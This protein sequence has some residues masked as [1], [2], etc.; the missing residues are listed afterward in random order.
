MNTHLPE[1]EHATEHA[2]RLDADTTKWPAYRA[3]DEIDAASGDLAACPPMERPDVPRPAS[4]RN[5]FA[6]LRAARAAGADDGCAGEKRDDAS[7]EAALRL[8]PPEV[9]HGP[10]L[11]DLAA[12]S[13]RGRATPLVSLGVAVVA[14]A[15]FV[16][17]QSHAGVSGAAMFGNWLPGSAGIA[18]AASPLPVSD[19]PAK[20][21]LLLVQ[22]ATGER[23]FM[24]V[25]T[26]ADGAV[27]PEEALTAG[28]TWSAEQFAAADKDSN[29][30]L[31][32]DEFLSATEG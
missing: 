26:D 2:T 13:R 30:T 4:P 19:V 1:T 31:S 3:F 17:S 9:E 20:R 11:A 14:A 23:D 32:A 25:D 18:A 12:M 24:K 28:W 7:P 15:G 10:L 29:G 21:A 5:P 6:R 8:L 16:V 27:T 22:A